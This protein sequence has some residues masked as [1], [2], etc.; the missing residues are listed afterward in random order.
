MMYLTAK[1]YVKNLHL[2]TKDLLGSSFGGQ[3][4]PEKSLSPQQI[5]ARY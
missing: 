2:R 3:F 4:L 5:I 1:L